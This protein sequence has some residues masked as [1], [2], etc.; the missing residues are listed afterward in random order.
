MKYSHKLADA[1]HL[2]AFVAIFDQTPATSTVI[3]DSI[4][5]NP[6]LVRRLMSQLAKAGLLATHPGQAG[7][8]L[9][10]PAETISLADIYAA[11]ENGPLLHVDPDTNVACPVGANIQASLTQAFDRVQMAAIKEMTQLSLANIIQ[12]IQTRITDR[13]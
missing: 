2:L 10:R 9:A 13:S 6:S 1:V 12:D 7:A 8:T 11:V 4:A 3:A 5:S